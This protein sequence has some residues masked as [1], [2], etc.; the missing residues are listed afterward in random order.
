MQVIGAIVLIAII[1]FGMLVWQGDAKI[2]LPSSDEMQNAINVVAKS[3]EQGGA[4][5]N[6][7]TKLN[8]ET[9][10]AELKS[11]VLKE[12]IKLPAGWTI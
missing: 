3:G 11:W 6:L 7:K 2:K 9:M 12:G 4:F 8:P 10:M 1:A 5:A